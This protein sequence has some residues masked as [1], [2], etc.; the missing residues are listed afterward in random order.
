MKRTFVFLALLLVGP[1]SA[2]ASGIHVGVSRLEPYRL[3]DVGA[4]TTGFVKRVAVRIG[5]K[6]KT[7]Q[8][9]AELDSRDAELELRMARG[10][11]AAQEIIVERARILA[12]GLKTRADAVRA[13]EQVGLAE[14]GASAAAIRE[15][16]V[17]A[18][19]Q[20]LAEAE[21]EAYLLEIEAAESRL[22][23]TRVLSPLQGVVTEIH[24]GAGRFVPEPG[25]PIVQVARLDRLKAVFHV[26]TNRHGSLAVGGELRAVDHRDREFRVTLESFVP[27]L[28][29]GD[30]SPVL[31]VTVWIDSPPDRPL[32]PGHRLFLK[33]PPPDS[34]DDE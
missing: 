2:A 33:L 27:E 14:R 18:L 11:L 30:H 21:A 23:Q 6:V 26:D 10:R 4:G 3:E 5:E 20:R 13:A 9:L 19:D 34:G 32:F 28:D 17:A 29:A 25:F 31:R 22:A 1:G 24:L 16:A 7:G 15:A 8:L 12:R